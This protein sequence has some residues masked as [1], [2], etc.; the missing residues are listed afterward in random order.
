MLSTHAVWR[1]MFILVAMWA[2]NAACCAQPA[3]AATAAPAMAVKPGL[4]ETTTVIENAATTSRRALVG[5]TCVVAADA[6]NLA[7][8]VPQQR[9]PGMQCENRDLKREGASVVWTIS[10]KSADA[11]H[12]GKGRL[13]IFAES[14]LGTA[15]VEVRKHGGKPVKLGQSFSGKWLQACS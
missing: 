1:A 11:V 13:S 5:R 12:T 14:Y 9:E 4:W 15:D 10:C 3:S 2:A 6:S 7:R 8:L